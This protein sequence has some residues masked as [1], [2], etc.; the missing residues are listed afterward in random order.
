MELYNIHCLL[1]LPCTC[2]YL[3]ILNKICIKNHS[4]IIQCT[5]MT[6]IH[7]RKSDQNTTCIMYEHNINSKWIFHRKCRCISNALF[8]L[9]S[10]SIS[11][12]IILPRCITTFLFFHF[13]RNYSYWSVSVLWAAE[14]YKSTQAYNF[15]G[16]C[17]EP[18]RENEIPWTFLILLAVWIH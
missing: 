5:C 8:P 6:F 11:L 17:R 7:I 16:N 4:N 13:Q 9:Y 10:L 15:S 18:I 12:H 1:H 3:C 14:A 2:I